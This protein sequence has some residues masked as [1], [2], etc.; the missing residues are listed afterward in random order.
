MEYGA[1]IIKPLENLEINASV[2]NHLLRGDYGK[3]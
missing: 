1:V 2:F 3:I